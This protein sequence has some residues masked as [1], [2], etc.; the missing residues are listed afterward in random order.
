MPEIYPVRKKEGDESDRIC[1]AEVIRDMKQFAADARLHGNGSPRTC[2]PIIQYFKGWSNWAHFPSREQLFAMTF[3]AV[4]HGANG[5]TWYTYGG[6]GENEGVTSTPERWRNICDLA[7]Q[8]SELAP[9]LVE[10]TPQQPAA[11]EVISGP[12]A[13]H[14]GAPSVTCLLKRHGEMCY[15]FA[16]NSTAEPV[17]AKLSAPN[18]KSVEVLREYRSCSCADG[19]FTDGFAPFAVHIYRWR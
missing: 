2:W 18:A 5:L 9:I 15:L 19:T 1:V 14:F 6:F 11:P 3:A 12:K 7:G 13:D 8:L 16:V 10:R 17:A 4:I